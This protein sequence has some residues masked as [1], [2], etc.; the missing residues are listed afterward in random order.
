MLTRIIPPITGKT[1]PLETVREGFANGLIEAARNDSSLVVLCADLADSL[2]LGEFVKQYP[3]Q[4]VEVGVAEQNLVGIAAGL[5]LAGKRPFAAS[6]AAFM[7]GR[8][9][10]QLR[11]SV[12]YSQANVVLMGSHAGLNVGADGATHQCLE[13]IAITRVLPNLTVLSPTDAA[14][15]R[16][17]A[18]TLAS[19]SGPVYVRFGRDKAPVLT[20]PDLAFTVGQAIRVREGKDVSLFVTGQ[21]I[22]EALIAAEKVTQE[23]VAVEVILFPTIKPLDV[24]A[25][26]TSAKK[27]GRVVTV[28]EGQRHGG[29][30]S[31]IGEVLAETA[32]CPVLRMGVNDAF[33]ESGTTAELWHKYG[34]SSDHIVAALHQVVSH[35]V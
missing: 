1:F 10:D 25:V 3:Q 6:Y 13:D 26:V 30:G 19:H 18:L 33:G 34:L 15:A 9:W 24:E 31:S 2:K 20:A 29:F 28:E 21:I 5:A 27:T 32:P 23:G 16:Q 14:E 4:Y 12:A 35:A 22:S 8:T 7:P 17:M 11:V